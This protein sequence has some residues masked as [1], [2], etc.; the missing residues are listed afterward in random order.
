MAVLRAALTLM[1]R[2]IIAPESHP[3]PT[4]PTVQKAYTTT[5]GAL[6]LPSVRWNVLWKYP[7]SQKVQNHQTGSV[8]IF[9][10]AQAH[11]SLLGSRR[12]HGIRSEERRVGKESG[13]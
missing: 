8:I 9:P 11:V 10:S 5:I 3:P 4:L 2:P 6:D 13:S 1:P 12:A 7:G